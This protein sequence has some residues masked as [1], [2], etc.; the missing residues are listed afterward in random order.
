MNLPVNVRQ[1][2]ISREN[3]PTAD[4]WVNTPH[5]FFFNVLLTMY[6]S[7]ILEINQLNAQILIL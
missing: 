6:L 3:R 1:K 5:G 2:I 7:I 4:P